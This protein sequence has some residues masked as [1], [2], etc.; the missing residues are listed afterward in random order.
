MNLWKSVVVLLLVSVGYCAYFFDDAT[1]RQLTREDGIVE[2]VGA[3]CFF[4]ASVLCFV[5]FARN[6][7][8]SKTLGQKPRREILL[9]LLG[10]FFFLCCGEEISWG[11]R[12]LNIE[13]PAW[14]KSANRQGEFNLHN[15][16]FLER[17]DP[18]APT[19]PGIVAES[20]LGKM[21]DGDKL[22]NLFWLGFGV[23]L[24]LLD[25]FSKRCRAFFSA[26][27]MPVLPLAFALLFMANYVISKSIPIEGS[28]D[29]PW[30]EIKEMNCALLL[31]L[32][33]LCL[34]LLQKPV[35]A[36]GDAN[37]EAWASASEQVAG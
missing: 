4:V 32:G 31:M 24:P 26:I 16:W 9:F 10:L 12:I 28:Y 6:R 23:G 33:S 21:I 35:E 34:L 27:N 7:K 20:F 37:P 17:A 5:T 25:R 19:E 8:V 29:H 36:R 15:M 1:I 14:L 30:V 3:F 11:Q 2:S 18:D 13:T 22:F